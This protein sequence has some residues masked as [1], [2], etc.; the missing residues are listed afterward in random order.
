MTKT[1]FTISSPVRC[2]VVLAV[3]VVLW[4]AIYWAISLP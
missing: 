2:I 4:A 3:L 1:L